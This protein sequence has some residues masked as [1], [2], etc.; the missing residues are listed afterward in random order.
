MAAS[1]FQFGKTSTESIK[2]T[3]KELNALIDKADKALDGDSNDAEHDALY[4]LRETL[5]EM[6]QD[7]DRRLTF[8][9][10]PHLGYRGV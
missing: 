3:V 7:P 1:R 4:S 10:V 2:I 9:F 6:S 5:S 8:K